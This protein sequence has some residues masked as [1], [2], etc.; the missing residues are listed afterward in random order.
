MITGEGEELIAKGR[1]QQ[2]RHPFQ[3]AEVYHPGQDFHWLYHCFLCLEWRSLKMFPLWISNEFSLN[4]YCLSTPMWLGSKN[5]AETF[6]HLTFRYP[7]HI[8][9]LILLIPF[10]SVNS[11]TRSFQR[12]LT[13]SSTVSHITV[14]DTTTE[15]IIGSSSVPQFS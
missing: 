10:S 11:P 4:L 12:A 3:R 9:S 14:W 13:A 15:I 5:L 2:N 1:Q 8:F 6:S 7:P